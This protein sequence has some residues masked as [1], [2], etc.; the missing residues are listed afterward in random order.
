MRGDTERRGEKGGSDL[1]KGSTREHQAHSSLKEARQ[2]PSLEQGVGVA[3]PDDE[4]RALPAQ[5]SQLAVS[6]TA[7]QRGKGV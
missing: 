5:S 3:K 6:W 4:R 7:I 1:E 2:Q